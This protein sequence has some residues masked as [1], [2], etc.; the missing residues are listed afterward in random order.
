MAVYNWDWEG[1]IEDWREERKK[2]GDKQIFYFKDYGNYLK[3]YDKRNSKKMESHVLDK[4]EREVFLACHDV[5]SF[6][7]LQ[8]QFPNIPKYKLIAILESFVH[9]GI[10]FQEDDSYLKLLLPYRHTKSQPS[11]RKKPKQ[12]HQTFQ[13]FFPKDF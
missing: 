11:K 10:V 1:L 5:I 9:K 12:S 2:V 7:K 6:Q 3:I 4:I 13:S 8:E